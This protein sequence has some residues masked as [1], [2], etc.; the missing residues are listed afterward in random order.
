MGQIK[1]CCR[2]ILGLHQE[3]RMKLL[4]DD[5]GVI[6]VPALCFSLL[7][8]CN[9]SIARTLVAILGMQSSLLNQYLASVLI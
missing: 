7:E 9:R 2:P 3:W 1:W 5:A 4:G 8:P 6:D